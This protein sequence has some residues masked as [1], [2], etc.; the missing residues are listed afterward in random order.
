[1]SLLGATHHFIKAPLLL[2]GLVQGA[3]GVVIALSVV[4][5]I[6]VYAKHQFQ[7]SLGSIFRGIDLQFLTSPLL[8][9]LI[10]TSIFVGL[11]GSLISINQFLH[12]KN[13]R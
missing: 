8:W 3:I 9:A 11:V 10:I 13:E 7:G 4:K 6:H 2:E 12:S 5:L 1:M